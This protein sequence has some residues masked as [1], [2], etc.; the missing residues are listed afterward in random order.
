MHKQLRLNSQLFF[1]YGKYLVIEMRRKSS[2]D[3]ERD[4]KMV[5]CNHL[6]HDT[7][8]LECLRPIAENARISFNKGGNRDRE[9]CS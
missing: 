9:E 6:S 5:K 4:Q 1:Y 2:K 7:H 3:N 8:I